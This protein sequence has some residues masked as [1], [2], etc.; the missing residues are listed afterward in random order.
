MKKIA[1]IIIPILSL[2]LVRQAYANTAISS[3]I[4]RGALLGASSSSDSHDCSIE[5]YKF[6]RP[7]IFVINECTGEIYGF[8][9]IFKHGITE[10]ISE[11]ELEG[12]ML[13]Q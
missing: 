2:L 5:H 3:S 9:Y 12:L 6:Q 1:F 11:Q 7:Y 10:R 13:L 4:S 8:R